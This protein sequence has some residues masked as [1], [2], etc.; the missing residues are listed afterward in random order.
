MSG[1]LELTKSR[2]YIMAATY[3]H[4]TTFNRMNERNKFKIRIFCEKVILEVYIFL[5]IL[6]L[7]RLES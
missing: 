7:N 3:R 5:L 4:N 1:S 2:H 6:H